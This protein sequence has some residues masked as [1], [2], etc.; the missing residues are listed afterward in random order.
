MI[1]R[2]FILA[3]AVDVGPNGKVFIHGGAVSRIFAREFPWTHPTVAV[4]A[5]L[6][7]T[8][9]E[10]GSEHSFAIRIQRDDGGE[11]VADVE[12][13]FRLVEPSDS[14]LPPDVNFA[15][16]FAGVRFIEAGMYHV[17]IEVDGEELGRLPLLARKP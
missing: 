16:T 4:F 12:S 9:D 13:P 5:R 1:L 8:R 7:G 15:M 6:E 2:S 14:E 17:T 3:D 11:P 10:I